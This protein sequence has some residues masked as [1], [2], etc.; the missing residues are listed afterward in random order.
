MIK[1]LKDLVICILVGANIDKNNFSF[2]VP[3]EDLDIRSLSD[4]MAT[5][6]DAEDSVEKAVSVL[7]DMHDEEESRRSQVIEQENLGDGISEAS[8]LAIEE[9]IDDGAFGIFSRVSIPEDLA[10]IIPFDDLDK[11]QQPIIARKKIQAQLEFILRLMGYDRTTALSQ[12]DKLAAKM[13]QCTR[14]PKPDFSLVNKTTLLDAAKSIEKNIDQ[15]EG[16]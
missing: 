2:V 9:V 6:N 11:Y 4:K 16:N 7:M 5:F 1:N 3:E 14:Y 13:Q 15:L 8:P 10:T 12:I